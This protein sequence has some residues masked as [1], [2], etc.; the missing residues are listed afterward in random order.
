MAKIKPASGKPR[1]SNILPNSLRLDVA[2]KRLRLFAEM[3]LDEFIGRF[4]AVSD[5]LGLTD[6]AAWAFSK[7]HNDAV[8]TTDAASFVIAKSLADIASAIDSAALDA[9]KVVVDS[10][11]L[12][13]TAAIDPEKVVND[14]LGLS[15]ALLS[16]IGKQPEDIAGFV[17]TTAF[18]ST[19]S[20]P[21]TLNM[22]DVTGLNIAKSFVDLVSITDTL[23]AYPL[24]TE[25][26]ADSGA[27]TDDNLITFGKQPVDT[28][29]TVDFHAF[30]ITKDIID[31][32]YS[33]DDIGAEATI[34]DNQTMQVQKRLINFGAVTDTV[35]LE[36]TYSRAFDDSFAASD[37]VIVQ[38][39][40]VRD[41]TETLI[42]GDFISLA[43]GF[44]RVF[45]DSFVVQESQVSLV[46][47]AQSDTIGTA[48]SGV[49]ISQD[50]VDNNLYFADD[51]VGE[52]RTF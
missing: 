20:V 48:D 4:V 47:K 51:Y 8:G 12:T 14:A 5:S 43:W 15:D 52:K 34:D 3:S 7:L 37:A 27:V 18:G 10:Y 39:S 23:N 19:K 46:G 26:A 36:A 40:F 13:D 38:V 31:D 33:T 25:D 29:I 24:I 21:D 42:A 22:I 50:Y 45:A 30:D 41:Q 17:D 16:V 28:S 49:L 32:L 2:S 11:S 1:L 9:S 35:A 6:L 44:N